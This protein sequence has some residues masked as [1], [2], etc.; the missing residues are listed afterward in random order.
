MKH[1]N[2]TNALLL[3]LLAIMPAVYGADAPVAESQGKVALKGWPSAVQ[4][5]RYMSTAD[6]TLQPTLFY[7]PAGAK[8]VPLLV[9]LHTWSGDYLQPEPAYAKWCIAKG[10][11]FVHPNF[12]GPN[13]TPEAC[14]S[15]LVVKDIISAVEYAKQNANIDPD[16]IYL[17]G[18]SGGAYAA[19]LLAGRAPQLWA[20]VSAWCGIFDLRDWYKQTS[21]RKLNYATMMESSCGGVPGTSAEVDAQFRARSAS[22]YLSKAKG[23]PVDLNTGIFD[24]HKGSVPTSQSLEA[25]NCLASPGD[26]LSAA[27]IAFITKQAKIPDALKK[28]INDPLYSRCKALL[29]KTSGNTR[30]TVFEGGH[31]MLFEAAFA[32]LEQQ[33]KGKPAV[34]D[35][36]ALSGVDLKG[37]LI[38]VGK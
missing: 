23:V 13:K 16:R 21:V 5:V 25:F 7:K 29:R 19:M 32:W 10:W 1:I 11:A 12:R 34:W 18:G 2:M 31:D 14:G 28:E 22:A 6:N 36:P 27:D 17:V 37:Q 30:V 24:G 38:E 20:G 9:A 3:G 33:R 4:K 8:P 26:R 15:E 35:V